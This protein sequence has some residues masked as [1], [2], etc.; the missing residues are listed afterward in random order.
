MGSLSAKNTSAKFSCLGTFK[1]EFEACQ[2]ELMDDTLIKL[3]TLKNIF[4]LKPERWKKSRLIQALKQVCLTC[5]RH[6][7]ETVHDAKHFSSKLK[8]LKSHIW[9]RPWSILG[10]SYRRNSDETVLGAKIFPS[11][12]KLLRVT[13]D[14]GPEAYLVKAT[15]ATL[16]KLF[17]VQNIF[18]LNWN[19]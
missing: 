7:D 10:W 15:D 9:C 8:L 6:T 11:K 14:A 18:R 1:A 4:H 17:L 16:V 19:S 12:L 2:V 5:R 13:F 3:S